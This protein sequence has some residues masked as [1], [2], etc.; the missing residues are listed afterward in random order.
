MPIVPRPIPPLDELF[1][2][3]TTN[4][5]AW[6]GDARSMAAATAIILVFVSIA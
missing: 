3:S 6:A 1:F 4:N 5:A 2:A